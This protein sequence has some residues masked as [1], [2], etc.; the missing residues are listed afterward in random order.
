MRNRR[1]V[2]LH[3]QNIAS[4]DKLFSFQDCLVTFEKNGNADLWRQI[5]LVYDKD[6]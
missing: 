6:A 3:M 4:D 5:L 1:V 2:A